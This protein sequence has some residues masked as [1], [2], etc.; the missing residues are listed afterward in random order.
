MD[1]PSNDFFPGA[2]FP[3]MR[4]GTSEGLTSA[5]RSI[6]GRSLPSAPTIASCTSVRPSRLRGIAY[7]LSRFTEGG[8]LTEP[9]VVL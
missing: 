8:E 2:G 9:P 3:N 4:T 5:T 1:G 6:T 7:R